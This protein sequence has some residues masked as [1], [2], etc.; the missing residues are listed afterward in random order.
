M[1]VMAACMHF[2]FRD[3]CMPERVELRNGQS[4]HVRPQSH[5]PV[6]LPVADDS[7]D[8]CPSQ[9]AVNGNAPIRQHLGHEIGRTLFLKAKLWMGVDITPYGGERICLRSNR[10][11]QGG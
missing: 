10:L 1:A 6:A 4:I 7:D 8:P 9:T 2:S 5:G 3:A 11:E